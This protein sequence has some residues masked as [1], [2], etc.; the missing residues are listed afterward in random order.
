MEEICE[1]IGGRITQT[2]SDAHF[3]IGPM[4][5]PSIA[6]KWILDSLAAGEKLDSADYKLSPS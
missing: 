2:P 4:S 6:E 5:V 1:I 3:C